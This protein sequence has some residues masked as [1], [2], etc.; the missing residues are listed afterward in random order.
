MLKESLTLRNVEF[1]AWVGYF[2]HDSLSAFGELVNSIE[3]RSRRAALMASYASLY[4]SRLR[5]CLKSVLWRFSD[6]SSPRART[7]VRW[8]KALHLNVQPREHPVRLARDKASPCDP[9]T[10]IFCSH[11]QRESLTERATELK[12]ADVTYV[13]TH[14]VFHLV[15][16]DVY[17]TPQMK[18]TAVATARQQ[19]C[20]CT[21]NPESKPVGLVRLKPPASTLSLLP[22]SS[23]LGG[24]LECNPL[25]ASLK[26]ASHF[27]TTEVYLTGWA[28]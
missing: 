4:Q 24:V 13:S 19:G 21:E 25:D 3:H 5:S 1:S 10:Y 15:R 7:N 11:S 18:G 9:R 26:V 16:W 8:M 6:P 23:G 17:K 14:E 2:V 28:D 20:K 22:P 27:S 12:L